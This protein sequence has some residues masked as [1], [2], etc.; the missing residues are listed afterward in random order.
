LRQDLPQDVEWDVAAQAREQADGDD[1]H[2]QRKH[3]PDDDVLIVHELLTAEEAGAV[4]I[5]QHRIPRQERWAGRR[6][7]RRRH[8]RWE[9]SD[10]RGWHRL[11]LI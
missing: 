8:G 2:A 6:R 9:L 3:Q 4:K 10:R 7:R 11:A 1:S 5:T